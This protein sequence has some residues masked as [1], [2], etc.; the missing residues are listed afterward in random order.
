MHIVSSPIADFI[1]R[2]DRM[3][4]RFGITDSRLVEE[5]HG[6]L[7]DAA[8]RAQSRGLDPDAAE[9]AAIAQFGTPVALAARFALH[10][11]ARAGAVVLIASIV[12]SFAILAIGFRILYDSVL[13]EVGGLVLAGVVL[14]YVRPGFAWVS[15]IGIGLGIVLAE[16]GFPVAPSAEHM[17]RYGPPV[18]GSLLDLLKLCAFP[19]AGALIG[20]VSRLVIDPPFRRGRAH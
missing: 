14:A 18:R 4:R 16:K 10:R 12:V 8:A 5:A 15:V 3:L 11:H 19:A 6:H 13:P 7:V 1:A 2:F 20:F 9:R 17:A